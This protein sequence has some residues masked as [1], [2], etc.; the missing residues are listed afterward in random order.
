MRGK[1]ET[2]Q[3]AFA[4]HAEE[5]PAAVDDGQRA[6]TASHHG[7]QRLGH[8]TIGVR[9]D[10]LRD[11]RIAHAGRGIGKKVGLWHAE[12]VEHEGDALVEGAGARRAHVLHAQPAFEIGIGDGR[13]NRI[14]VRVAMADDDGF[15]E[16]REFSASG[17]PCQTAYSESSR[18]AQS[19]QRGFEVGFHSAQDIAVCTSRRLVFRLERQFLHG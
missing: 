11:H 7:R 14:H 6:Q 1:H 9:R 17:A 3:L 5:C 2:E 18:P 8:R 4:D 13:A 12:K 10:E 16:T 15:H 19:C